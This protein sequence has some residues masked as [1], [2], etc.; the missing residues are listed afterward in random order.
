MQ[1]MS[2]INTSAII[3]PCIFL[4]CFYAYALPHTHTH[5]DQTLSKFLLA[6][7]QNVS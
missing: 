5:T 2:K 4:F 6:Y 7:Q 1:L 3:D